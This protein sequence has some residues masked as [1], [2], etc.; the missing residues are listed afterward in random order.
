MLIIIEFMLGASFGSFITAKLTRKNRGESI[1]FPRSH[2]DSCQKQLQVRDLIPILGYLS[3]RGKCRFCHASITKASLIVELLVG[4]LFVVQAVSLPNLLP[5][6]IVLILIYLSL[7]DIK[8]KQVPSAGLILLFVVC[9]ICHQ[10]TLPQLLIAIGC[11]AVIQLINHRQTFLGNG[12]IDI[13]FCLWLP[14]SMAHLLW[15]LCISCVIA[16]GYLI[17]APWPA[18][19]KIPFVPFITAAYIMMLHFG[20]YLVPLISQFP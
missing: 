11:Y 16:L 9:V 13:F 18:D 14:L 17:V 5:L 19:N 1:I 3:L 8:R 10:H 15:I 6:A 12:D 2:C 20:T 4:T 7:F